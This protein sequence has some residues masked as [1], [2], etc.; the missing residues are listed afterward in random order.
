MLAIPL[1][2]KNPRFWQDSR[3]INK[4]STDCPDARR[5]S[6]GATVQLLG[7][8]EPRNAKTR[9]ERRA[10]LSAEA[11]EFHVWTTLKFPEIEPPVKRKQRFR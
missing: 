3:R 4:I 11:E 10:S 9:L 8:R 2:T 5:D 1:S 6:R 7:E